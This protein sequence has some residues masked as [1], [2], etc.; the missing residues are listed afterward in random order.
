MKYF[1]NQLIF[2]LPALQKWEWGVL[3]FVA[4][5]LAALLLY[6]AVKKQWQ[7]A[8]RILFGFLI[9]YLVLVF[10]TTVFS[11]AVIPDNDI[12]YL[13]PF[14][15]YRLPMKY[16]PS[17]IIREIILNIIMLLPLGAL[18]PIVIKKHKFTITLLS[19]FFCTLSIE[20][21]QLVRHCGF[22]ETDD[23][24]HNTLGVIIG[25]IGYSLV[26]LLLRSI[27]NKKASAQE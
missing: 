23:L 12:L 22:F 3:C 27:K 19:G 20:M 26:S 18:L 13:K 6:F 7:N 1:F 24:F 10:E 2:A 4:A 8:G 14:W 5:V 25:Y 17:H 9:L 15:S 16:F 11:R 21:L